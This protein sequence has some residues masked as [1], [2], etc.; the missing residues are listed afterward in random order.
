MKLKTLDLGW[1]GALILMLAMFK[2]IDLANGFTAEQPAYQ[3][4]TGIAPRY[5]RD[6]GYRG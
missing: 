5:P 6:A 1:L 3:P 2:C 4:C